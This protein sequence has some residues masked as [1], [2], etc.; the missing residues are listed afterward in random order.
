MFFYYTPFI[1]GFIFIFMYKDLSK[2]LNNLILFCFFLYI[3]LLGGLRYQVGMDWIE[4]TE[5]FE[6]IDVNKGISEAYANQSYR[7]RFEVGYFYLNYIIKFLGGNINVV[8]VLSSLFVGISSFSLISLFRTN[9]YYVYCYYLTSNL[10]YMH[11]STVRQSIALGFVLIGIRFFFQRKSIWLSYLFFVF[12]LLFQI[13]SVM[14]LLI[15]MLC[16]FLEGR[17]INR[18]LYLYIFFVIVFFMYLNGIDGYTLLLY[19]VPSNLSVWVKLYAEA[20]EILSNMTYIY[21]LYLIVCILFIDY[22]SSLQRGRSD[23]KLM[24]QNMSL[25]DNKKNFDFLNEL[26]ILSLSLCVLL[27]VLFPQNFAA[28]TRIYNLASILAALSLMAICLLK[29]RNKL[30]LFIYLTSLILT[31]IIVF[32]F[33]MYSSEESL[34]PYKMVLFN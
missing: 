28:W 5:Y 14:Y 21:G 27:L 11:F 19:I 8:F 17:I 2:S 25:K 22:Y 33:N 12:G 9:N 24:S 4:Y 7:L 18:R 30:N 26:A 1:V 10:V 15:F 3:A 29:V 20:D 6:A 23:Y 13:S 34:T 31:M 32:I 16:V